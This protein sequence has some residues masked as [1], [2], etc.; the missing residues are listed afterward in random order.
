MSGRKLNDSGP[1]TRAEFTLLIE[2]LRKRFASVGWEI[3]AIA[4]ETER[5]ERSA[6]PFGDGKEPIDHVAWER[7][8]QAHHRRRRP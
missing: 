2:W 4:K 8:V 7:R 1:V 3:R 5:L 6:R